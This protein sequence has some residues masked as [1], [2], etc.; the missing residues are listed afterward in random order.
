MRRSWSLPFLEAAAGFLA[1]R[2]IL[3]RKTL[4]MTAILEATPD[5][6]QD[7]LPRTSSGPAFFAGC[8]WLALR[9]GAPLPEPR[10]P[11]S[12]AGDRGEE[13]RLEHEVA[14]VPRAVAAT[15]APELPAAIAGDAPTIRLLSGCDGACRIVA[16]DAAEHD[17]GR[18][19][20]RPFD[21]AEHALELLAV[22]SGRSME[23]GH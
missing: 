21:A 7:F 8:G 20:G 19:F 2:S 16:V 23:V 3:R 18:S 5:F 10:F 11:A 14:A 4:L 12:L 17:D 22:R 13:L 15:T 9:E 6:V 1:P